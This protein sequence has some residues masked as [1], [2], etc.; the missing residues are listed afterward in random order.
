MKTALIIGINGNF[1]GQMATALRERGW[2]IRALLRNPDKAPAWLAQQARFA[3]AAQDA[4]AVSRAADGV[5]LIVYGANPEYHRWAKE[6]MA[7]LEPAVQVAEQKHLRIVFPGNVYAFAPQ[8]E[9]IDEQV[10]EQP[11]TAKGAIRLQMEQRLK[12]ASER[13]AQILL[14]RAGDFIGPGTAWTWWDMMTKRKGNR[15]TVQFPHNGQH[16]HYWSYLPDLSSNAALLLERDLPAWAVYHDPGLVISQSDWREA[17][18]GL[19]LDYR[20]RRFPWWAL[21]AS[22][23][24][25]PLFREVLKM[26]YLWQE[27]VIMNGDKLTDELGLALVRTPLAQIIEETLLIDAQEGAALEQAG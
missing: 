4:A 11:P 21:R 9:A 15:I 26:R 19:N 1:G 18:Q 24:F 7:M 8:D 3:G 20:F 2:Q 23:L 22:A 14:M 25:S 16:R 6:A 12:R 5:D 13:G 17:L 27:P 10:S